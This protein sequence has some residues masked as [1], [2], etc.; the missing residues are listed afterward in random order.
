[1]RVGVLAFGWR[2]VKPAGKDRLAIHGC[3]DWFNEKATRRMAAW[4]L[5]VVVVVEI[6]P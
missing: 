1:V 6:T 4:W 3:E 5:V 2:T